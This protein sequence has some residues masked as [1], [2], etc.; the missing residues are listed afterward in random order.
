MKAFTFR[1]HRLLELRQREE[2]R[3]LE[4][5]GRLER[6]L[7]EERRVLSAFEE[8]RREHYHDLDA[9]KGPVVHVHELL[10]LSRFVVELDHRIEQQRARIVEAEHAVCEARVELTQ[11]R[12]ERKALEKLREKKRS[13]WSEE[14]RRADARRMDELAIIRRREPVAP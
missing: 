11:A 14:E 8:Q 7:D 1:L 4:R 13:A 10:H 9:L 2:D 3:L 6:Q 12:L 5:Q